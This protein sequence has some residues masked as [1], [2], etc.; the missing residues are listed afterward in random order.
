MSQIARAIMSQ[1]AGN[2]WGFSQAVE[3]L[4]V[5]LVN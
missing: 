2:A 1:S 4:L 3:M 5:Q